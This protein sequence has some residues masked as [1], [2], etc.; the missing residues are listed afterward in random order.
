MCGKSP[1]APPP[2]QQRDPVAEQAKAEADAQREANAATANKRRRRSFA[3]TLSQAARGRGLLGGGD[4][5]N[6]LLPSAD[7]QG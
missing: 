7:P 3:S 6:T 5:P 4:S 2:V 1:K